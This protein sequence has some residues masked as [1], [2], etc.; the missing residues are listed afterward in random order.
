MH[1]EIIVA[2]PD[3]RQV[4]NSRGTHASAC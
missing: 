4:C 1:D 3:G 2:A